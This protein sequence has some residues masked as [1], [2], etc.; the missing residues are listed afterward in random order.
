MQFPSGPVAT[1]LLALLPSI[2]WE[3]S[4]YEAQLNSADRWHSQQLLTADEHRRLSRAIVAAG[5]FR[6]A[7]TAFEQ[8]LSLSEVAALDS[9]LQQSALARLLQ[10][11]MLQAGFNVTLQKHAPQGTDLQVWNLDFNLHLPRKKEEALQTAD[12]LAQHMAAAEQGGTKVC[13]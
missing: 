9:V 1:S 4:W 8:S 2:P 12:F 13:Q 7:H 10:A 5:R 6:R 3:L 11:Q